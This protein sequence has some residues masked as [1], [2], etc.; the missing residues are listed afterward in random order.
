M[1]LTPEQLE[2]IYRGLPDTLA[3][4]TLKQTPVKAIFELH[5]IPEACLFGDQPGNTG[6]RYAIA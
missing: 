5:A 2:K 6:Q 4:Y 3:G 1:T